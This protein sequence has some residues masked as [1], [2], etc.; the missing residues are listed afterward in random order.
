MY[1][2]LSLS[3]AADQTLVVTDTLDGYEIWT[4]DYQ[5][6]GP[7]DFAER[8]DPEAFR[9][10]RNLSA[11][12]TS[13]SALLWVGGSM[14]AY[15]ALSASVLLQDPRTKTVAGA[16]TLLGATMVVSGF[17]LHNTSRR[18]LESYETWWDEP[19]ARELTDSYN[20][21]RAGRT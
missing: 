1:L 13:G 7:R 14:L 20:L 5:R 19:T 21:R 12:T 11:L 2:L 9:R 8:V 18:V 10:Y 15:S 17:G 3:F 4:Q 16:Y 6:V